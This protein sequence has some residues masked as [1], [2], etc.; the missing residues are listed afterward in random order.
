MK[1]KSRPPPPL[2]LGDNQKAPPGV[3][4]LCEI[5]GLCTASRLTLIG[6]LGQLNTK[7]YDVNTLARILSRNIMMV[8]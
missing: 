1:F 5:P 6:A 2:G 3:D 7:T 4:F 8:L